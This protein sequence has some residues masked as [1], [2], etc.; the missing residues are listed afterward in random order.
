MCF[1][2]DTFSTDIIWYCLLTE[3]EQSR[4]F[5]LYFPTPTTEGDIIHF[6]VLTAMNHHISTRTHEP[7]NAYM[8]RTE[9]SQQNGRGWF[10]TMILHNVNRHYLLLNHRK[11]VYEM[12]ARYCRHRKIIQM[13]YIDFILYSLS[14]GCINIS[15]RFG[16]FRRFSVADRCPSRGNG[17][18]RMFGCQNHELEIHQTIIIIIIS[19]SPTFVRVCSDQINCIQINTQFRLAE[20][21]QEKMINW[22]TLISE[23]I[24]IKNEVYTTSTYCFLLEEEKQMNWI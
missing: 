1:P 23:F 9:F 7:S 10:N 15:S 2:F 5:P 24:I 21:V 12:L 3:P 11:C 20:K 16:R 14:F 4:T 17:N 6:S 19:S 22:N 18:G 13:N 8:D